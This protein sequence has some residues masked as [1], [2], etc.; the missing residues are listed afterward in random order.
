[1]TA[2]F[3]Y[4]LLLT[5]ILPRLS[6]AADP[7]AAPAAGQAIDPAQMEKLMAEFGRL[8]PQHERLKAMAGTYDCICRNY[9]GDPNQP[10]EWKATAVFK[11]LFGGRYIQQEF[12][13]EMPGAIPYQG[14][15]LTGYDNAKQMYVGTWVDSM[16]TGILHTEGTF[17]EA[18]HTATEHGKC[19]SPLGEMQFKMVTTMKSA[20]GFLFTM[21]MVTPAGEQKMME[22]DYVRRK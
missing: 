4:A 18:T 20:D 7:P 14:Q 11:P 12:S 21:S 19:S 13:G 8:G 9:E 22:I 16:G 5:L 6:A 3:V 2:R 1:M 17:D 15:G 10:V